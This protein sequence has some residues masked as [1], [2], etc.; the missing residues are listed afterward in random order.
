MSAQF[1]NNASAQLSLNTPLGRM[2]TGAEADAKDEEEV[3]EDQQ[4]EDAAFALPSFG[5]R[6]SKEVSRPAMSFASE[7]QD[8]APIAVP[9]K[10]PRQL[11]PG[12]GASTIQG[13]AAPLLHKRALFDASEDGGAEIFDTAREEGG[14]E[15]EA[16]EHKGFGGAS[17][18][19]REQ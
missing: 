6:I 19:E 11:F 9:P 4:E 18:F 10:R 8:I 17:W 3:M 16:T 2:L 5:L 7:E 14:D 13:K 1:R 12:S 15:A